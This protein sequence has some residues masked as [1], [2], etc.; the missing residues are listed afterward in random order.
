MYCAHEASVVSIRRAIA[1]S[2]AM[3][4]GSATRQAHHDRH[5]PANGFKAARRAEIFDTL[6]L[7]ETWWPR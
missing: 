6:R 4:Q 5:Q 2:K 7:V 1:S 3:I